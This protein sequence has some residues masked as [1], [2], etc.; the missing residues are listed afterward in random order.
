MQN[1]VP[2]KVS[3][4]RHKGYRL[5]DGIDKIT[6]KFLAR[7]ASDVGVLSATGSFNSFLGIWTR[8]G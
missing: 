3:I 5:G 7:N 8:L 4:R 1:P 6:G 2:G